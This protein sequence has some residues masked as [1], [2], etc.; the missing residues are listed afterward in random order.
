MAKSHVVP[1]VRAFRPALPLLSCGSPQADGALA[2]RRVLVVHDSPEVAEVLVEIF[3]AAGARVRVAHE[4]SEANLAIGWGGLDLVLL[5]ASI[6]GATGVL[7]VI[8]E[9][10]AGL[11]RQTMVMTGDVPDREAVAEM[12][13][14]HPLPLYRDSWLVDL[15]GVATRA[16]AA[17]VRRRAVA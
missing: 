14:T 16:L 15:V 7:D 10:R 9:C 5:D 3:A 8:V 12:R 13:A 2:G 1:R 11:L 17:P 6:P 4:S